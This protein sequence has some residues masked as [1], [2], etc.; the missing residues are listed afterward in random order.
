MTSERIDHY[1]R[2]LLEPCQLDGRACLRKSVP[3]HSS[4]KLRYQYHWLRH[5][6]HLSWVP[7]VLGEGVEHERY[8]YDLPLLRGPTLFDW[9]HERTLDEAKALLSALVD[10]LL[11]SAELPPGT[12]EEPA[13]ALQAYFNL[14]VLAKLEACRE[15]LGGNHLL[16]QRC[17]LSVNGRLLG[18]LE[19]LLAAVSKRAKNDP[20]LLRFRAADLHGDPT[21]ENVMVEGEGFVILDPNGENYLSDRLLDLAKLL[22]SLHTGFE[23]LPHAVVTAGTSPASITFSAPVSRRY[24]EL[25][26]WLEE[27]LKTRF[28]EARLRCLVFH[29]AVHYL[30]LLPYV[31]ARHPERF[32]VYFGI[33]L[34][35]LADYRDGV[36]LE[37]FRQ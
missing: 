2:A 15:I 37:G 24:L 12:C 26:D 22:Q 21:I 17:E 19:G 13:R 9:L 3:L 20:A 23:F 1:E 34:R 25:W 36:G 18:T 11:G 16:A 8:Y 28:D 29:E 27:D 33:A 7:A 14:K 31:A 5:H 35:L 10:C 30:R 6:A 32:P 4:A